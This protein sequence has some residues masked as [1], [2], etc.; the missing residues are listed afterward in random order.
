LSDQELALLLDRGVD[1]VALSSAVG[2]IVVSNVVDLVLREELRGN[3][4][5]AARNNLIN[6]LAVTD[7]LR[8]LSAAENRQ[9]LAKMCLLITSNA[10]D[11]IRIRESLLRLLELSHVTRERN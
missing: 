6:P 5:R 11:E 7:S 9:A 8:A 2:K 4:P 10:D 3:D 1:V